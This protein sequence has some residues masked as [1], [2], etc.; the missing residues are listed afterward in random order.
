LAPALP[1]SA[2]ANAFAVAID[3]RES[4]QHEVLELRA[5]RLRDARTH[6]VRSPARQ[7]GDGVGEVV[8]D[9]GVVAGAP[10]IVSAPLSPSRMLAP[11]LPVSVLAS[12]LPVPLMLATPVSTSARRLA[13]SV[14]VT[15]AFTVSVP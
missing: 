12:V 10:A 1:V 4:A 6:G 3:V 15:L 14:K 13:A 7:L 2:L 5:E 9:V 11:A 8:D